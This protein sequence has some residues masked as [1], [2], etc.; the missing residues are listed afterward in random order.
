MH[1]LNLTIDKFRH[2]DPG[3]TLR[4]RN[5][6][7]VL[8]G[9]NAT[10]KTSFLELVAA[11][12]SMDFSKFAAE[13]FDVTFNS[14]H[15]GFHLAVKVSN[16]RI[17]SHESALPQT[18]LGMD[19]LLPSVDIT[20]RRDGKSVVAFTLRGAQ[21]ERRA[22]GQPSALLAYSVQSPALDSNLLFPVFFGGPQHENDWVTA[23]L[24]SIGPLFRYPPV[25]R[26]DESLE[27]FSRATSGGRVRVFIRPNGDTQA[28]NFRAP[29]AVGGAI[30]SVVKAAPDQATV[31]V[32][33]VP[34]LNSV[35]QLLG[36]KQATLLA[37]RIEKSTATGDTS[38]FVDYGNFRVEFRRHDGSIIDHKRLSYGQTRLLAFHLW[39]ATYE[40][41]AVADELVNGLHHEW[42]ESCISSV[43]GRQSFLTTQ[44]PLLLDYL[45]FSSEQDV[46]ESFVVCR[47]K[48]QEDCSEHL[49]WSNIRPKD[50][51]AFF[52]AYK[53]GIQ[54]VSEILA[55]RGLW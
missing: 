42:I 2:V 45:S 7:N 1:L 49:Q 41:P 10:G 39:L 20:F 13:P 4:F 18:I 47:R 54:H 15:A 14:A 6:F 24:A 36:F 21:A 26:L 44:N 22:D 9:K 25:E 51:N 11:A 53:T 29:Q 17:G 38:A 33:D 32:A 5:G 3:T 34:F 43:E 55:S 31:P 35:A 16:S 52:K 8:L 12:L 48:T 30:A 27:Y 40:G 23:F 28:W 46:S 19:H 50:A 37:E